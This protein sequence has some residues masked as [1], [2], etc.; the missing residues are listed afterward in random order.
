MFED[1]DPIYELHPRNR[2]PA[3]TPGYHEAYLPPRLAP[4]VEGEER[5][6]RRR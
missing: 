4:A 2:T 5:W 6:M 3:S 1:K